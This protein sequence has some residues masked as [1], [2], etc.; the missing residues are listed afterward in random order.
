[1]LLHLAG[2]SRPDIAFAVDQCARYTFQ[3]T[4]KHVDA[5]KRIGRYFRGTR[6]KGIIMRPLPNLQVDFYPDADFPGLY[7]HEDLAM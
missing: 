7:N 6:N 4:K 3:P 5:L 1:M 2:H